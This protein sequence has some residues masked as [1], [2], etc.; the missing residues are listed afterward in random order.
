VSQ[1]IARIS[2]QVDLST[3]ITQEAVQRATATDE[4]VAGLAKAT[5]RIGQV[6]SLIQDI[7]EQ[8]NLLA[9]NTTIEAARAGDAG[10]GFAVVAS[11]VKSLAGQTAK[12]TETIAG[13][14]SSIQAESQGAVEAIRGI[15]EAVAR[16]DEVARTITEAVGEQE[17]TARE[18]GAEVTAMAHSADQAASGVTQVANEAQAG[19]EAATNVLDASRSLASEADGLQREITQFCDR[20]RAG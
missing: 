12:A 19:S 9:L 15:G 5:D 14:I 13:E 6:L 3:R 20:V 2:E 8:T 7:A 4:T 18:L 10:K 11:E 1:A 16:I 17:V